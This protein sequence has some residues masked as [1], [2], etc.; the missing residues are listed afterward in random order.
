MPSARSTRALAFASEGFRFIMSPFDHRSDIIA[1]H[2]LETAPI[3]ILMQDVSGPWLALDALRKQ[4]VTD[5]AA[6][7]KATPNAVAELLGSVRG[8]HANRQAR[9]LLA[10]GED[11][12]VTAVLKGFLD[13]TENAALARDSLLALWAG[14][15]IFE[16]EGIALT[17][18]GRPLRVVLNLSLPRSL[19]EARQAAV[20][21]IDRTEAYGREERLRLTFDKAAHGMALAAP[22]GLIL[23]ANRRFCET[24]GVDEDAIHA[25]RIEDI[26]GEESRDEERRRREHLL[27]DPAADTEV[28]EKRFRR[29]NG[30]LVWVKVSA[31]LIRDDEGKARNLLYQTYD[32]TSERTAQTRAETAESQL[33][34]AIETVADDVLLFDADDRLVVVNSHLLDNE[35]DLAEVLVPGSPFQIIIQRIA[36]LDLIA[37]PEDGSRGEWLRWRLERFRSADPEPFE[38]RARDGRWMLIRQGRAADGSTLILRSDITEFK[39]REIALLAAKADADRA[40]RTKSEFLAN[41]SHELHTPLNAINGFSEVMLKELHGPLGAAPYREYVRNILQSGRH[42][43]E[44][45]D[46]I[47]D[48]SHVESGDMTL[49]ETPTRP[50]DLVNRCLRVVLPMARDKSLSV[51]G[52]VPADAPV[53]LCD[54]SRMRQVLT[55][56]LSNAIKFTDHGGS[57]QVLGRLGHSGQYILSVSDTGCGMNAEEIATAMTNFGQIAGVFSRATG[58]TGLGLPL[59]RALV[60]AHGGSL[61]IISQPGEGTTVSVRFPAE[62]VR[63]PPENTSAP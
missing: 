59:S 46:D 43:L 62:R 32:M 15:E 7:F 16:G 60:E 6:H 37:P 21:L 4:G 1:P 30:S 42:L 13:R 58:G 23:N 45:I 34:G 12:D 11:L 28:L 26:G 2:G 18:Q 27:S 61:D 9:A 22:D 39:R 38:V 24:L 10:G 49:Q 5:L 57:I 56:L 19:E 51:V 44:V 52:R 35:P 31:T 14:A 47:L 54:A 40:N 36:E 25:M 63:P 48:L 29:A 53:L 20:F 33:L 17:A 41:M 8:L 50:I 55:N 3:A